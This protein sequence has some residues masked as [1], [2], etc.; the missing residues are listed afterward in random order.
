VRRQLIPAFGTS[1]GSKRT[2]ANQ[3]RHTTEDVA[4]GVAV[5]GQPADVL[6][7]RCG[8]P[9]GADAIDRLG[10]NEIVLQHDNLRSVLTGAKMRPNGLRRLCARA[11]RVIWPS[12]DAA[13]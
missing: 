1:I 13:T 11:D 10:S 2:E 8:D 12:A 5:I 6:L 7:D 3:Y 4:R 9:R